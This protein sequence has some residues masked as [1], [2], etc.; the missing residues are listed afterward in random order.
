MKNGFYL[1]LKTFS[2]LKT[3]KFLSWPFGLVEKE[4]CL[5]IQS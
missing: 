1:I 5:E 4:D 2:V 3:L